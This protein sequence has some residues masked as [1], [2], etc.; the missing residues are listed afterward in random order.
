[1]TELRIRDERDS[2]RPVAPLKKL[3]DA[4]LLDTT[5]IS[6][7]EAVEQVLAWYLDC[8]KQVK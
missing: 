5:V 4:Y 8:Q 3:D 7:D 6:A 1:V 2:S